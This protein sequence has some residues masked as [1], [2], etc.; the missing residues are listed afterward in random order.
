M[1]ATMIDSP[2]TTFYGVD[3]RRHTISL[4]PAA[5]ASEG[6]LLVDDWE[7]HGLR[8]LAVLALRDFERES[9]RRNGD[10]FESSVAAQ[11]EAIVREYRP[12]AATT[13]R[14][15]SRPVDPSEIA[16]TALAFV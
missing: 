13:D 6:Q 4:V 14:P 2:V 15:L 9:L 5:S 3:G 12:D 8:L 7:G 16:Q 1:T 11:A 10:T